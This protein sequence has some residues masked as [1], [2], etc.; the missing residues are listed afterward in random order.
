VLLANV[1]PVRADDARPLRDE[2]L[3]GALAEPEPP[4]EWELDGRI[5][6]DLA[7]RE[8]ADGRS[9]RGLLEDDAREPE[10]LRAERRRQARR[11]RAD[12][13]DVDAGRVRV[14]ACPARWRSG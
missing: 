6:D 2:L 8:G 3:L 13:D 5:V 11:S 7:A 9:D 10:L 1:E 14:S 4:L 12:D